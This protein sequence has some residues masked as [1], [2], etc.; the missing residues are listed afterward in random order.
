MDKVTLRIVGG[1]IGALFALAS[2][3]LLSAAATLALAPV[4]G[5]M[6][7]ALTVGI[8]LLLLSGA[9]IYFTMMPLV[10]TVTDVEEIEE[11]TAD[12]LADLPF[13]TV[14]SI[15]EKRPL[16][17]VGIAAIAGYSITKDPHNATK[18]AERLLMGLF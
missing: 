9:G 18:N 1:I 6:Y 14:N 15:V 3:L 13:E 2:V 4:I 16:T 8:I 5:Y 17:S 12:V 11:A 10:E 7:A